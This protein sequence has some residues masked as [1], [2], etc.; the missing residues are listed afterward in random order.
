MKPIKEV[1]IKYISRYLA[2]FFKLEPQKIALWILLPNPS[3]GGKSCAEMFALG[4]GH[5]VESWMKLTAIENEFIVPT[6]PEMMARSLTAS[7]ETK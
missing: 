6:G 3:F 7:K 2:E 4:R 1:D 5:K